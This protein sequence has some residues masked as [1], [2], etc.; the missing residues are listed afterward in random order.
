MLSMLIVVTLEGLIGTQVSFQ[1]SGTPLVPPPAP[2][3]HG[4][5]LAGHRH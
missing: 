1:V 3:S 5:A 2:V 4:A